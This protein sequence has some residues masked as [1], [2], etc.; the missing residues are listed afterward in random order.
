MTNKIIKVSLLSC[1]VFL[2]TS[3]GFEPIK[4]S[5]L[6][7]FTI[8]E[9]KTEGDKRIN[10]KIKNKLLINS[11]NNNKN[12]VAI[13]IETEKIKTIKEKNIKNQIIKY[14]ILLKCNLIINIL[15]K[16]ETYNV[17]LSSTSDYQVGLSYSTTLNNEKKI[18]D[19]LVNNIS[20]KI[21]D[22]INQVLNDL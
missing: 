16:E 9:V 12:L 13:I 4:G 3:C 7:N 2:S 1:L 14:K 15:S 6:D 5:N 22:E 10:F 11:A 19:T 8:K 18:T 17:K 20:D 21:L